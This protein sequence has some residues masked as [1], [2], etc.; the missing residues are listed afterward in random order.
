MAK[1][2]TVRVLP[3]AVHG[4]K[5]HKD[6]GCFMSVQHWLNGVSPSSVGNDWKKEEHITYPLVDTE[7]LTPLKAA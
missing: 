4:A 5:A 7:T 1:Y 3:N 2:Y 6:G